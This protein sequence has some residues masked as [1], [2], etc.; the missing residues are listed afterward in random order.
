MAATR[1]FIGVVGD[2]YFI[3][4]EMYREAWRDWLAQRPADEAKPFFAQPLK[5]VGAVNFTNPEFGK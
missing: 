5:Y 4:P 3:I 2:D 1:F